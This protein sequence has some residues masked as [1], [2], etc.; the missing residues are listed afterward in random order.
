MGARVA[1]R[2][3]VCQLEAVR[4]D[5]RLRCE[6]HSAEPCIIG[7]QSRRVS[8]VLLARACACAL[9]LPCGSCELQRNGCLRD[10]FTLC[11][12]IP[13]AS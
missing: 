7:H 11:G 8:D 6:G 13:L 4:R 2:A 1:R 9:L 10:I 12:V 5:L 3:Y